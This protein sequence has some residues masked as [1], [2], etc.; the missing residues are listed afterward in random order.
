M[1]FGTTNIISPWL[2]PQTAH[3]C[4]TDAVY[5]TALTGGNFLVADKHL[6]SI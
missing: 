5:H 3:Y 6:I 4:P 2:R 1:A